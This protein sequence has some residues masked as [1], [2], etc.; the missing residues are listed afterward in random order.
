MDP[1]ARRLVDRAAEQGLTVSE[2]DDFESFF[3]LHWE[4]HERKGVPLYLAE[5]PFREYVLTLRKRGLLRLYHARLA[6]GTV[7]SSQIVLAS[8]HPVTHTAAAAS[9]EEHHT[10]GASPFLRWKVFEA[11]GHEGFKA[12]DLTG[13]GT[14]AVARFKLQLASDLEA[15]MEASMRRASYRWAGMPRRLS[16]PLRRS[17]K[18]VLRRMGAR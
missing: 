8:G 5:T 13:A 18:W 10:T 11:L 9:A 17:A 2:D 3:R 4:V 15:C 1:N 12:N 14:G 7:A 16:R 6:D